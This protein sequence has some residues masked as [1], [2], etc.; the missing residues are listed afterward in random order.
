MLP[1][2]EDERVAHEPHLVLLAAGPPRSSASALRPRW[3]S[4]AVAGAPAARGGS[5]HGRRS[6]EKPIVGLI[7]K[8]DTNP[9]FVKM[10]EGAQQAADKAGL[11]LQTLRGQ[12]GRRQRV[13]GPGDR[14]PDL[15]R[16]QGHPDHAE[17]LEGDRPRRSTRP[18]R[19]ACW[20]IALDTPT[21]PPDAVDATFATDNFQ[22]GLL[23]GEWAKAKFGP[24]AATGQDRD[25]RPER[26]PGLR[27]RQ[28]RPGL[29]ARAS[30]STS[31][32]RPRS[33]TRTTR[34]SSATT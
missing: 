15:R 10:K 6:G 12:A 32:T 28:A 9:F 13:P 22:A 19:R 23:I 20:S 29:P 25:A 27:R 14:E 3:P 24:Q 18:S 11:T 16:R 17:R 30:A 4:R 5:R 8:T 26:Q 31:P 1:V 21:D 7:T 33:V 34:G 2:K